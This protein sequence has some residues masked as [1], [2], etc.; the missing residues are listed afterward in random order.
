MKFINFAIVKFSLFLSL[1]ILS[2]KYFPLATNLFLYLSLA[3]LLVLGFVWY[4][5]RKQLFPTSYFGIITFICFINIGYLS[6]QLR[7]PEFQQKHYNHLLIPKDSNKNKSLLLQL[8]IKEVLK[9]DFYNNKYIASVISLNEVKSNGAVLVNI[10]K[11]SLSSSILNDDILL[12]S[13]SIDEIKVPL[14]PYQFDYSKYMK[15]LGVYHQIRISKNEILQKV[16]GSYTLG[17]KAEKVRNHILDKLKKSSLSPAELSIIQALVLG[18]KKDISKQRYR[19][20][21]AAGAIHILAVSG[22]H[23]GIVYF[24][25]LF[26]LSPL[27]RLPKGKVI[28]SILIVISLWGYAFITGLSPSVIRAVTMFSFFAFAKIINRQTNSINT[29]FLSYFTLLL[30][31]PMWLFQ[32][33][34]QLSYLAVFFILWIL[35]VFNKLYYTKNRIVKRLWG[36]ITVTIAAQLGIIPLS[37][38]YFHQFPGLFF[39]TNIV[40]LPFLS[41]LL[42]GGILII[43][44]AVFNVLPNWLTLTYNALIKTLNTFISWVANQETFVF[45]DIH[46]SIEKVIVSYVLIIS[47]ILLW[48]KGSVLKLRFLLLSF[49]LFI[50]VFIWDDYKSSENSLV[51]FQK[52]RHTL[53]GYQNANG[54]KLFRS[55]SS[56]NYPNKYP[57]KSY[58]VAKDIDY[59]TEEKLPQIIKYNSKT[60]LIMDSLGV[61]PKTSEIDIVLLSFNPKVNLERM[62][63]SLKPKLIIADGNNY[64]SYISR[65][66]KT[67][68]HK[69]IAFYNTNEKGAYIFNSE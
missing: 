18:Q 59:Y 46:F 52:F 36:I 9:P 20:Y 32:V 50:S 1:G 17:G 27:K 22:L 43:V 69:N 4:I 63:D 30:L 14:N 66:Q 45:Q 54:L 41:I 34:F 67:C 13:S 62:V 53:I 48:K 24:I 37:L 40:V 55:D 23:V 39:I 7:L 15:T 57:I 56:L 44:L 5:A 33:G 35:P 25:F 12:V 21:A 42:G 29:L 8:K 16:R 3:S 6:Y 47:I 49:A 38:Y 11:D 26:V 28:V 68:F 31:N 65:W 58:R 60:I 51:I 61:Y 19:E 64:T 2:A 10:R